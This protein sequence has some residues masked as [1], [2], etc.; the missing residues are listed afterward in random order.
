MRK[1]ITSVFLALVMCLSLAVPAF[2]AGTGG[3]ENSSTEAPILEYDFLA[4]STIS[5]IEGAVIIT[6]DTY[7]AVR[8][9]STDSEGKRETVML[10]PKENETSQAIIDD[11]NTFLHSRSSGNKFEEASDSTCSAKAY[12]TIYYKRKTEYSRDLILLTKVSGGYEVTDSNT[13]IESQTV[14]VGCE[15]FFGGPQKFEVSP[16]LSPRSWS[17]ET[18]SSW[19][20]VP[21]VQQYSVVG[22]YYALT[23]KRVYN[24]YTW[25]MQID[26]Y[27][28]NPDLPELP[29]A[30]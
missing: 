13:V 27:I 15:D 30:H 12:M 22:G 5:K 23:L 24:G 17:Y 28:V 1:K 18:P 9:N 4:N 2:A 21:D 3:D 16:P 25:P 7:N 6:H 14:S 11:I 10:I 19:E 26:N 29:N 20:Y 8:R